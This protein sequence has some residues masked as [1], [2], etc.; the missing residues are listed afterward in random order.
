MTTILAYAATLGFDDSAL[1][2]TSKIPF[3]QSLIKYCE[4][5]LCGRYGVNYTC[6][7]HCGSARQMQDKVLGCKHAVV[8]QSVFE[9]VSFDNQQ[10]IARCKGV[11]AHRLS[12]LLQYAKQAYPNAFIIGATGCEVCSVCAV[13]EGKPCPRPQEA[14]SC[15]SAY[16]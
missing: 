4:E 10:A 8:V 12:R 1:V 5:N 2:P 9:G 6:P 14:H 3:D 16:G 13:V 7:P 15:T 11:H